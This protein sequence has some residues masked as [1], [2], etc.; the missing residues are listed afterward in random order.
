[1]TLYNLRFPFGGVTPL[2][3]ALQLVEII[4]EWREL[5]ITA[6]KSG[7]FFVE[8]LVVTHVGTWCAACWR[9]YGTK[10][11]LA[12]SQPC[13]PASSAGTRRGCWR[14]RRSSHSGTRVQSCWRA[15][16]SSRPW[17][18]ERTAVSRVTP[19]SSNWRRAE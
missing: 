4:L 12:A 8:K 2:E 16:W 11:T 18:A 19:R 15:Q 7:R 14:G 6:A 13:L 1:M 10:G 3:R 5:V 17:K 9:Q